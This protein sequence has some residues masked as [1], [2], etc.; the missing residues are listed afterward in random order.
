M[1]LMARDVIVRPKCFLYK[2]A[3]IPRLNS[4]METVVKTASLLPHKMHIATVNMPI[5]I[6]AADLFLFRIRVKM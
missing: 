1:A 4:G 6:N 3:I 5:V 2:D